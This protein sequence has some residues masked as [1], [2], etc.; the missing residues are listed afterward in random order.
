MYVFVHCEVSKAELTWHDWRGSDP[1]ILWEAS[2][3]LSSSIGQLPSKESSNPLIQEW[4]TMSLVSVLGAEKGNSTF[5][6]VDIYIRLLFSLRYLIH[7]VVY[8]CYFQV[9][10]FSD[11]SSLE[12]ISTRVFVQPLGMK[13]V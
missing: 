7:T 9:Q 10:S 5:P 2:K 13:E 3:S 1:D 8:I 11:L 4:R 12:N 6:Y